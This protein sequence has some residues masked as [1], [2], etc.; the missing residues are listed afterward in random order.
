[1]VSTPVTTWHSE[2]QKQTSQNEDKIEVDLGVLRFGLAGRRRDKERGFQTK[3]KIGVRIS[4]T[5]FSLGDEE[6]LPWG[7]EWR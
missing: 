3:G 5:H 6:Y 2:K 4:L 1:M 7:K